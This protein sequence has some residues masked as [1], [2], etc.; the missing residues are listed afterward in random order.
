MIKLFATD[1]DGTFLRADMSYDRALF[2]QLHQQMQ[3][4]GVQFVVASG[5]QYYQL[6]TFFADYPDI[7]FAADN[8]AY[9]RDIDQEYAVHTYDPAVVTQILQALQ[10]VPNIDIIL[11]GQH[12]AF[13]LDTIRPSALAAAKLYYYNLEVVRN[14]EDVTDPILKIWVECQPAITMQLVAQFREQFKG[15]AEPTSSGHGSIDLIQPGIHKAHALQE[16]GKLKHIAMADMVAFGDGGNDVEMLQQVGIGVAMQNA[17][18]Q[19]L[20][21]ADQVTDNNENQ[22]VLEFI[23]QKLA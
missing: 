2:N 22:G 21:V 19:V 20:A 5:N 12:S 17:L 11:S 14:F 4:Q 16:I 10:S 9:V 1:M 13:V 18:P 6:K 23:K 7:I 15:L 8:G 3:A